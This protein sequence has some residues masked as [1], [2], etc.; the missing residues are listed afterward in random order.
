MKKNKIIVPVIATKEGLEASVADVVSLKI[1]YATATA[2]MELEIVAVQK[3]HQ[4]R[5][6]ELAKQIEIKETSV[7]I[8]CEQHRAEL[9]PEKK[10]LDMLLATVGFELTP[11]RVEKRNSRDTWG[12]I[13]LKL[14]A[15]IW[16]EPYIRESDPDVDK[17][18]LLSDRTNLTEDQ[19]VQA[20]IRF[21]QDEN[22]F[23]K[24]KSEVAQGTVKQ[25]A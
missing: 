3:R 24:P 13:A 16:G 4:N 17:N 1:N 11:H 5:I 8:Y 10:S 21:E 7:Q 15:L 18:K 23:I 14:Q 2:A 20:G 19:L 22:F 12:K 6:L 9:F 25:A